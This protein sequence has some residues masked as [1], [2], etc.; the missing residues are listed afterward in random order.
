MCGGLS[1]RMGTDKGLIPIGN[2]CWS[3]F[4]VQK[5]LAV[6]LPFCISINASQVASYSP[7]FSEEQLVIDSMAIGGPLNGLL[8]VHHKYPDNNLLLL[9]C[10]MINMQQETLSRLIKTFNDE[11]DH[12]FYVYQHGAFAEPFCGIYTSDGLK[13]VLQN[14]ITRRLA[15]VEPESFNNYNTLPR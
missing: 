4:M 14:G 13:K 15:I 11:P 2:I 8:S 6:N 12:D 10:D 1:L 7:F 3:A 5:L 9:A